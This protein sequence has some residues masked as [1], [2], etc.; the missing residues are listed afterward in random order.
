MAQ[1]KR[2]PPEVPLPRL[3]SF[4]LRPRLRPWVLGACLLATASAGHALAPTDVASG[5]AGAIGTA[6]DPEH[7]DL[8]FVE[9]TAGTLK[10]IRLTPDCQAASPPTC[11]ITTVA[12]GFAH[13]EDIAL[14][15]PHGVGYV[16]TRDD[17]GTTG[18]L[19]RVNLTTGV[20]TLVTFNLGAPQQIALD[21]ATDTA[22]VTGFDL[23][24]VWKITLGTG[25]K[26]PVVTGLGHPV[27]LA[28]KADRTRA[29]V[30]L[31]DA[32]RRVAEYDLATGGHLRDLATGLT[33]PF[34]LAW[35]DPAETAL[36]LLE[37]DPV[38]RLRRIDVTTATSVIVAIDPPGLPFR[39]SAIATSFSGGNAYVTTESKVVRLALTALPMGEPVFLAVGH[40]PSTSIQDGYATTDP[41]YFFQV[42][43][44]PFGGTL[45]IFGNFTNFRGLGATHYRVMLSEGGGPFA[46]LSRSW[47]AYRWNPSTGHYELTPVAPLPPVSPLPP[48]AL[49]GDGFYAIAAEYPAHPERWEPPFLMMEWPSGA[50][51][52]VT[53]QVEIWSLAGTTW[54]NLTSLLPT[55]NSMTLLIDNTPP[56]VDLVAIRQHGAGSP[57]PVCAIVTSGTTQFDFQITAHDSN[58]HLASYQLDA[59]WGHNGFAAGI[60]S[61][62]YVPPADGSRHWSGVTNQWHTPPTWVATCNCAH[63][64]ILGV[65]KR[66]TNGYGPV[67]YDHSSQSLT[68]NNTGSTCP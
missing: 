25:V 37:R 26:E 38:N 6:F 58:Q 50:N 2:F 36:W 46:P 31:Q 49:V 41:G 45:N 15:V 10:R 8:Y 29:Y 30:S 13:P 60:V 18:S 68:I 1:E 44:A 59:Y 53:F 39:P 67:L 43:D 47:N 51:G 42:K 19:W 64:F 11:V 9:F 7:N 61:A 48:G 4:R 28:V 16:T 65:W 14:D 62:S 32:P 5:L 35:S 57:L 63:T 21:A 3:A 17:V 23:G 24:R 66:T 27:G 56:N 55:G 12:S 34:F 54:T 40:I 20:R 22:F 52:L 33:A